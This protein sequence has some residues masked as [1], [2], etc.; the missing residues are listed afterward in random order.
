MAF[1]IDFKCED[2]EQV[3]LTE[4]GVPDFLWVCKKRGSIF[5]T[6]A[7]HCYDCEKYQRMLDEIKKVL[8][9]DE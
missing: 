9:C 8:E 5:G 6:I 7:E 2:M 4:I 3:F 1:K